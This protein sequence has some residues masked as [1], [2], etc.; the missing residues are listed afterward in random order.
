MQRVISLLVRDLTLAAK[1]HHDLARHYTALA[2]TYRDLLDASPADL[3]PSLS[4][5]TD[6][7]FFQK[8]QTDPFRAN[9][10]EDYD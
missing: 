4:G 9:L 3:L 7:V 5:G 1:G 6:G 10:E 2:G 8:T